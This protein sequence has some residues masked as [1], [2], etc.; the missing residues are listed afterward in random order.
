MR[1]IHMEPKEIARVALADAIQTRGHEVDSHK[2]PHTVMAA[3]ELT[4]PDVIIMEPDVD[5]VRELRDLGIKTPI[6]GVSFEDGF[7][8]FLDAGGDQFYQKPLDLPMV[9]ANIEALL[10]R[11]KGSAGA[12]II[13][14]GNLKIDLTKA[15]AYVGKTYVPLSN[16]EFAILEVMAMNKGRVLTKGT[17]Y[18]HIYTGPDQPF[19]KI[20]D[21]YICKLRKKLDI[22]DCLV[23]VHGRGYRLDDPQ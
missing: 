23:T 11:C 20:I 18:D 15:A 8:P 13:T 6:V 4:Q 14:V 2:Y 7:K 22:A 5:F 12:N 10:R 1:I 3:L 17:I 9:L 16:R 19:D 21:V